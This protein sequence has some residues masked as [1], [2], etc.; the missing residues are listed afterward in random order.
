MGLVR[1]DEVK[2]RRIYNGEEEWFPVLE[3]L[4]PSRMRRAF[5]S[6]GV[7][8]Q[9][10]SGLVFFIEDQAM[11]APHAHVHSTRTRYRQILTELDP[12]EVRAAARTIPG[13]F[14]VAA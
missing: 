12:E 5:I 13:Q 1:L 6:C 2:R 8:P 3:V 10:A 7:S 4:G 14:K 11:L 9:V